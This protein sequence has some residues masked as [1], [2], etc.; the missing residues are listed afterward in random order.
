MLAMAAFWLEYFIGGV[1][2]HFCGNGRPF[3]VRIPCRS[4]LASDGDLTADHFLPGVHI[5]CCGNGHLW[6]RP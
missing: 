4:W 1:H 2:I 6:F 3:G 5:H